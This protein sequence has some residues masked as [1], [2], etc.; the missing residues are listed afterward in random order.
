MPVKGCI[1]IL[2]YYLNDDLK[3]KDVL[4]YFNK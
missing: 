3:G 4:I 2:E 1:F